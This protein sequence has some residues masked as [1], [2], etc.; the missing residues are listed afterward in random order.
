MNLKTY[1]KSSS[2]VELARKLGV[3][4]GAV[5]QWANG[6]SA[7]PAERCPLIEQATGGQVRCEDLRPDVAWSVL[8]NTPEL[9]QAHVSTEQAATESVAQ[10][11]A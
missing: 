3:T 6:L 11:V 5:S 1:L 2:Q 7:V 10:G 9:A 4:A 8:R